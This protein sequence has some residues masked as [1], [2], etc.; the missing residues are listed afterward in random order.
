MLPALSVSPSGK[1][2]K[3]P[4]YGR[5]FHFRNQMDSSK[6]SGFTPV[7]IILILVIP[8]T[9]IDALDNNLALTPPMGWSS[10][11]RFRCNVDCANYP[12]E[13]IRYNDNLNE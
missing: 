2:E 5:Y 10:W 4:A 11:E 3:L 13:C 1:L 8:R 7:V 12:D 9:E 6:I